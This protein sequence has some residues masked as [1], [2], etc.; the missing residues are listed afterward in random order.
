[1]F[2]LVACAVLGLAVT[3]ARADDDPMAQCIATSDKGLDLR[4]QGKLI[5]ARRVLAACATPACGAAIS[6]VC[7]KRISDINAAM[8]SIILLP[9]DAAG[10]DVVGV[11]VAID[12]LPTDQVLDGRPIAIDPGT[13][14]FRLEGL[15]QPPIERSFVIAEGAKDR[16]ERVDMA[17][18]AARPA[19][20]A[21]YRRRSPTRL[22]R[23]VADA[24]L[25]PT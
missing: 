13:H 5:D 11:K 21:S 14:T 19:Q 16:Q 9:K 22:P 12:G 17:P 6:A 3:P 7:Q 25:R 8:P 20:G 23:R 18:A 10:Q 15:G 2:S 24:R 1:M 4:K